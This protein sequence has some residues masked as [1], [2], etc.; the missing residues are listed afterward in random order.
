MNLLDR[1]SHVRELAAS[2]VSVT[3]I[4]SEMKVC[5]STVVNWLYPEKYE[6]RKAIW[7]DYYRRHRTYN[8]ERVRKWGREHKTQRQLRYQQWKQNRLL[9]DPEYESRRHKQYRERH[10]EYSLEWGRNYHRKA[11]QLWRGKQ[12]KSDLLKNKEKGREGEKLAYAW[13]IQ[14]GYE[15]IVHL[16]KLWGPFPFDFLAE[17]NGKKLL[18][19]A[20]IDIVKKIKP[21][22]T[23][24][25]KSL[26]FESFVLF[27]RPNGK[28]AHLEP[29]NNRS[30]VFVPRAVIKECA[31]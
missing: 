11:S 10:L 26:G 5:R 14:Q 15:N 3:Q 8:R 27:V 19:D 4:A 2:G 17:K 13:L 20:T 1:N 29:V 23:E 16:S 18:I 7:R 22:K 24:L 28:S 6:H 31:E 21:I 9:L 30:I 25:A 12:E